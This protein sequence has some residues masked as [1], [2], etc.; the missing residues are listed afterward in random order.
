MYAL[1]LH[2]PLK[3]CTTSLTGYRFCRNSS[4]PRSKAS[5]V[6]LSTLTSQYHQRGCT[7]RPEADLNRVSFPPL[8]VKALEAQIAELESEAT[9]LLKTI[10]S[11]KA[12]RAKSERETSKK[13]EDLTKELASRVRS[14]LTS[15][16]SREPLLTI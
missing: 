5:R 7:W 11:E 12:A 4:E 6:A 14:V 16:L 8:R 9:R 15:I 3:M 2:R 10:D 1:C 13:V